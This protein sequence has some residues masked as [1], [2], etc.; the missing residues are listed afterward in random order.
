MYSKIYGLNTIVF[1]YFNIYGSRQSGD[2]A[3]VISI[4]NKACKNNEKPIVYGTGQQYRDFKDVKDI[5]LVNKIFAELPDVGGQIFC[6]GTGVKTTVNDVFKVLRLKWSR[7]YDPVH[8]QERKGDISGS[9]CDNSK[10][11]SYI[12]DIEFTNFDKGVQRIYDNSKQ[13]L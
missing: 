5:A 4:F 2:Y 7:N 12:P 3:G 8:K 13:I 1:R 9:L 6:V 10:L 11:K